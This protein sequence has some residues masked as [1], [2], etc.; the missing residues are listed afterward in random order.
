[1]FLFLSLAMVKRFGELL[2]IQEFRQDA[3]VGRGYRVEDIETLG[4]AGASAGY[5]SVLVLAL[6]VNSPD[7]RVLYSHPEIIWLLCPLLL[8]WISRVWLLARRGGMHDDPVVFAINDRG[9]RFLA[10][11]VFLIVLLAL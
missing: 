11:V 2:A 5:L 1:M 8:Y 7:V 10:V 4:S 6:Y 3:A 9:S